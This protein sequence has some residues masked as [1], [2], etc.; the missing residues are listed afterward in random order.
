MQ[1]AR[2]NNDESYR[3][4]VWI[5]DGPCG[6]KHDANVDFNAHAGI[7]RCENCKLDLDR[8][9]VMCPPAGMPMQQ[10]MGGMPMQQMQMQPGQMAMGQPMM[11]VPTIVSQ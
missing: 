4:G 3:E 8:R 11:A 2:E 5:C 10:T 7:F 9:C 1:V 6:T